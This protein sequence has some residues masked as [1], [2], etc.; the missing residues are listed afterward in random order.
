MANA[1]RIVLVRHGEANVNVRR[2]VGGPLG[3]SGLTPLGVAQAQ[4]L[5]ARLSRSREFDA[6]VLVSSP[7]ARARETAEIAL[8]HRASKLRLDD[9]LEELRVGESDGMTFSD[10]MLRWGVPDLYGA[11]DSVFCP[12]AESYNM[13]QRRVRAALRGL[14]DRHDGGTVMAFTHG[15]VIDLS[16]ASFFDLPEATAPTLAFATRHTALTV[17]TRKDRESGWKLE[18]YNDVAHLT[19]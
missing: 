5:A 14:A 9:S 13:F 6:D 12:G 2:I 4:R 16:F 8:A 10:A 11:P 7:L 3:D 17:W 18:R 15:G 19:G 1:T